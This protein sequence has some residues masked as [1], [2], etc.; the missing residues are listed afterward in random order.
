VGT[1][2]LNGNTSLSSVTSFGNF[3]STL[4]NPR[5]MEFSLRYSF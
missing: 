5:V 2:S 1:M 4:S 3:S